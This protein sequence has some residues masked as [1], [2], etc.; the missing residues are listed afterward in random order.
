MITAG[1]IGLEE[2]TQQV[3]QRQGPERFITNK[4]L[5]FPADERDERE[6]PRSL[7]YSKSVINGTLGVSSVKWSR[8]HLFGSKCGV[9]ERCP[10]RPLSNM[11]RCL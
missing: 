9:S 4:T 10:G 1:S 2:W 7:H 3:T 5:P 6:S 8:A 11:V